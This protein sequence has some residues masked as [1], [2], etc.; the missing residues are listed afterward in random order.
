MAADGFG[1][2]EEDVI[3]SIAYPMISIALAVE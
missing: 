3:K 1:C 2:N